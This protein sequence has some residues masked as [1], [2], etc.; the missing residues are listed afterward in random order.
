MECF[1]LGSGGMMPMPHRL[2]TS[3]AVRHNGRIILFDAGEGTQLGWKKA[4]LGYRALDIIAVSH[5]HADH[6]LGIPGLM[7]LRAQMDAPDLLTIVGPPG[8][9][10]FVS[11]VRRLLGFH[12]NFPV[13]FVQWSDSHGPVAFE[14]E[15][16][17]LLWHPLKHTRFC[18]G[19]RLEERERSGKFD[20]RKARELGI[21]EG[22]LWGRLQKGESVRLDDARLVQSHEVLGPP[23][24]GRHMAYVVDTRPVKSIYTLCKGADLAFMEGMF[25]RREDEQAKEKGHMT[26]WDAARI[27]RRAEVK[28]AVLVHV[29]PRYGEEDLSEL[30]KEAREQF[31]RARMG[32]DQ[33]VYG[34]GFPDDS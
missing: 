15:R 18:L 30:E 11:T 3:V 16:V 31:P 21:P 9:E 19:F 33:D 25:L 28:E 2:L 26:V 4:R 5:L 12:L 20:A 17:R 34:V 32:R 14:D 23:R 13:R 10:E 7:M 27:A 29:S 8:I 6:C 22:P 1:L 24:R